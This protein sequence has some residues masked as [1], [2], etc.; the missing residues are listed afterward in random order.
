LQKEVAKYLL[1]VDL[2]NWFNKLEKKKPGVLNLKDMARLLQTISKKFT[3]KSTV[4]QAWNELAKGKSE[5]GINQ[6]K[7]WLDICVKNSQQN[8]KK[9]KKKKKIRRKSQEI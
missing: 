5:I 6:L 4:K 2:E 7:E 9:K 3:T 8:Q 1:K